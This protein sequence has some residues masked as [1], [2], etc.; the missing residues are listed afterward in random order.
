MRLAASG[1]GRIRTCDG[2]QLP[3]PSL[4]HAPLILIVASPIAVSMARRL[5]RD[6]D[7]HHT[8]NAT[9]RVAVRPQARWRARLARAA[10]PAARAPTCSAGAGAIAVAGAVAIAIAIA[11]NAIRQCPLNLP[12]ARRARWVGLTWVG[13]APLARVARL[14]E[15]LGTRAETAEVHDLQTVVRAAALL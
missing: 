9:M 3:T 10:A 8:T 4:R 6:F 2:D 13:L 1:A 14:E 7:V 11:A 12:S 5:V 15:G